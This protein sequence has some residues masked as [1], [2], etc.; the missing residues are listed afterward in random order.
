[1]IYDSLFPGN[2]RAIRS[3]DI[4]DW[5]AFCSPWAHDRFFTFRCFYE[6]FFCRKDEE[7]FRYTL[8]Q[9][10]LLTGTFMIGFSVPWKPSVPGKDPLLSSLYGLLV[11]LTPGAEVESW[12][13]EERTLSLLRRGVRRLLYRWW[14][15][16]DTLKTGDGLGIF[17]LIKSSGIF[18]V[19]RAELVRQPAQLNALFRWN[20][21]LHKFTTQTH[22][23]TSSLQKQISNLP[24]RAAPQRPVQMIPELHECMEINYNKRIIGLEAESTT[25]S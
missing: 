2:P 9:C 25:I 11:I 10:G 5:D 1:M 22:F 17:P 15:L 12:L 19:F 24:S 20:T 14:Q 4:E 13:R 8:S 7:K 21:L 16:E 23:H 6:T 18:A 3:L